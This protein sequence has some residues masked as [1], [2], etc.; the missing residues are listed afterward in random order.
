MKLGIKDIS[1]NTTLKAKDKTLKGVTK[2][3]V[4]IFR[5]LFLLA[6]G[7]ILIYPMF[8]MISRSLM[9]TKDLTD[10]S[11]LWIPKTLSTESWSVAI[12]AMD[13]FKTLWNTIKLEVFSA[14]L[15][16]A[17]CSLPA[18]ALSRYKFKEKGFWTAI[19]MLMILMPVQIITIPMALNF[20]NLDFLGILGLFNNLTG[21]DLRVNVLNTPFS[22]YLPSVL[23]VGLRAGI[24][25]YIY[26]QFFKG[27]PRELEEAAWV[28]GSGP[29]RTFLKIII[30]SSGV[31]ILTVT[32]FAVIWHWNDYYMAVMYT[33]KDFPISVQLSNIFSTLQTM[34]YGH[35]GGT[36]QAATCASCLLT[37]LPMLV[38][39]II[40]QRKFIESVDRVGI[41]G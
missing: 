24:L 31:V 7:Y 15:E 27:L 13:Y 41:V 3:L 34:G 9:T 37:I 21:I 38:M 20:R 40:L 30:P 12:E 35:Y 11:V 19:L 39:Y 14:L 2:A 33:S 17:A 32:I 6:L 18:Y 5:L 28:D 22:F 25:I 23:G 29:F 4:S 10:P 8:F 16:V 26:M 1:L 36:A